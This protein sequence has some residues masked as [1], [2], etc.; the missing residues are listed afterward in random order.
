MK[1]RKIYPALAA[2]L[3]LLPLA[4][5]G[6]T[7]PAAATK[8]AAPKPKLTAEETVKE[9]F[10]QDD[11]VARGGWKDPGLVDD[12]LVPEGVKDYHETAAEN[13]EKQGKY[14]RHLD[15][16]T[17]VSNLTLDKESS[18][19]TKAVVEFCE[20]VPTL[21]LL[22][23]NGKDLGKPESDV[24]DEAVNRYT[25][26]RENTSSPWKIAEYARYEK[27]VTCADYFGE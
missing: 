23:K 12:L 21:R 1:T 22:D 8:T 5:C 24:R 7:A 3:L 25:L 13:Y 20:K 16:I 19:D 10:K 15:I 6:T 2:A 11:K 26:V 4:G 14:G 17:E 9:Y 18:T 27:G